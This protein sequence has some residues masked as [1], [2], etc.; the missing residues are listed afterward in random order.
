M[1]AFS[2]ISLGHLAAAIL[3]SR[4][5]RHSISERRFS[6]CGRHSRT[7][8]KKIRLGRQ[9]A[10]TVECMTQFPTSTIVKLCST[11][12]LPR[13]RKK[14][15]CCPLGRRWTKTQKPTSIALLKL[16]QSCRWIRSSL[17]RSRRWA[18]QMDYS[19]NALRRNQPNTNRS[20]CENR[21]MLI[22]SDRTAA[23]GILRRLT[24]V[25][26]TNLIASSLPR[27]RVRFDC[28]RPVSSAIDWGFL[29]RIT[30][31]SARFCG[32]HNRNKASTESNEIPPAFFDA[33][34]A[35]RATA[36]IS[37]RNAA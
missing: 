3:R 8:T 14:F 9:C 35:P 17:A 25:K 34:A 24:L 6:V 20:F 23:I 7:S 36:F 32:V 18:T 26:R 12:A 21:S 22:F 16:A 30:A 4:V 15:R 27:V 10:G 13:G 1:F 28:A 11:A 33:A 19:Q 31:S 2:G 29:S 37:L 5:P